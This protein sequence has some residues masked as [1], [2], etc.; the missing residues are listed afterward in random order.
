MRTKTL[1]KKQVSGFLLMKVCLLSLEDLTF[2]LMANFS[3]FQ[4]EFGTK[5]LIPDLN[6]V[7][8][9]IAKHSWKNQLL[10]CQ[11]MESQHLYANS[12]RCFSKNLLKNQAFSQFLITWFMQ[13]QL[14]QQFWSIALKRQNPSSQWEII[15]LL[16]WL[17]SLGEELKHWRFHLVMVFAHSCISMI[18]NLEKYTSPLGT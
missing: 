9:S 10:C 1:T 3:Y 18:T 17:T 15:T 11:Q 5:M 4:Q 8:S 7:L 14:P 6:T 16:L 13:S 2:I 12:V